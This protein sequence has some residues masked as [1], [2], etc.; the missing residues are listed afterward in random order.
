MSDSHTQQRDP[1]C[2]CYGNWRAIVAEAT[3]FF[4]KVFVNEKGEKYRF[5][6]V[7]HSDDDYYYGMSPV[8]EGGR[9]MLLSCVGSIEGHGFTLAD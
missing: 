3:P 7:V 1:G 2:I 5:F 4:N 9:L 8:Q 6:G